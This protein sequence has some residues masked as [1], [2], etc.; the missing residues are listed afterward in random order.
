MRRASRPSAVRRRSRS[1]RSSRSSGTTRRA[2]A[3]GVDAR[4]SAA[5][6]QSGVSCSW[7]TAETIGTG[8]VAN[9]R[10]TRSSL[11]GRRSSK[12]PPPRATTT[13]STSAAA[14]SSATAETIAAGA[15]GP[16][17]YVSAMTIR[18]ARKR[19][20]TA[21]TKSRFAAASFPVR[22]PI[23]RGRT[24]SGRLRSAANRPSAASVFLSRSMRAS[25]AP[26]P[27]G[28]RDSAR[29]RKLP[30]ASK[31]SGR[32]KT[33]TRSPSARSR[34]RPSNV[35]RGIETGRHEPSSRSLRVKKTL[36][37]PAWR[38]SS[39]TSP[40]TQTVGRRESQE[41]MPRLNADT[42]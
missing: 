30:R 18:A 34:R 21:V 35:A 7:P 4:A 6:S 12:L 17:T 22:S 11:K 31:I 19:A 23:L 36:C 39:V 42:A 24:G 15:C 20:V 33:C 13:T 27:I 5:R 25:A 9:A 14:A 1:A 37:H 32:P 40:S 8:Q 16:W 3:V 2:A 38:R 10:T 41:A 28:S 26:S 29:N